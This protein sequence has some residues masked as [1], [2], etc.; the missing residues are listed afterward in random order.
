M[1][2]L[3]W[4]AS[5]RRATIRALIVVALIATS[6]GGG[7]ATASPPAATSAVPSAQ[8][9]PTET[10][11]SN[12]AIKI[13]YAPGSPPHL[14]PV[15]AGTLGLYQKYG[16]KAS[17]E[18][19][20]QTTARVA[21]LTG[22]VTDF[23]EVTP[24]DL[25]SADA[26]GASLR[27]VL[28]V[29][30]KDPLELIV[31][32]GINSFNDLRG[33][34]GATF[35]IGGNQQVTGSRILRKE[36]LDPNKDVSWLACGSLQGCSAALLAGRA[37]FTLTSAQSLFQL[38]DQGFKVL[39]KARDYGSY[40]TWV[41]I[42]RQD[43]IDRDPGLVRDVVQAVAES[44]KTIRDDRKK[45]TDLLVDFLQATDRPLTEKVLDW[46]LGATEPGCPSVAGLDGVKADVAVTNP[47]V[48]SVA[49]A[50]IVNN[51]FVQAVAARAPGLVGTMDCGK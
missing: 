48:S 30:N 14:W 45:G 5:T 9:T 34:V 50:S 28:G 17:F 6:C 21:A 10:P 22:K 16:L 19:S 39:A 49:S 11:R 26:A 7:T 18:P 35:A 15:A 2:P 42:T 27:I 44:I 32:P 29:Q 12:V 24:S 37:D 38:Q 51:S 23:V 36:G 41:L 46:Y 25:F 33:K 4:S 47:A 13:G 8:G 20:D 40:P 1:S 43:L 31:R 3:G